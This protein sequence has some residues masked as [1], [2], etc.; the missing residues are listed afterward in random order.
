MAAKKAKLKGKKKDESEED[1]SEDEEEKMEEVK[2][3]E[4]TSVAKAKREPI[5]LNVEPLAPVW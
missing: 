3:E 1:S 2:A 5:I 4:A